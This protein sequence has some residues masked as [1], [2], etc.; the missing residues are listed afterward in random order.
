[1]RWQEPGRLL[2]WAARWEA[3]RRCVATLD[4]FPSLIVQVPI[5]RLGSVTFSIRGRLQGWGGERRSPGRCLGWGC[6]LGRL[7]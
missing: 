6:L 4:A 5:H 7:S 2:L 3:V 1:M